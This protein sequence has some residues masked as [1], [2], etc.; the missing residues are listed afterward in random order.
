MEEIAYAKL[1]LALHVRAREPDGY[2]R[3]ETLFAF[4]AD[5]DRLRVEEGEGLSLSITGPFAAGL[6]AGEDN[7][8][9]R[10]A[11]ALRDRFGVNT[12]AH[13]TLEKNLPVASGIGGGSADAAAALRLLARWWDIAGDASPSAPA[14]AGAQPQQSNWAPAFAGAQ[15]SLYAEIEEIAQTLGADVPACL[16]SRT[17]RG[18]GRG[19]RLRP[20]DLGLAG[21][22]VL[23]VNPRVAVSTAA[24]FKGWDGVD[25]GPMPDDPREARNDLQPPAC[26]LAPEIETVLAALAAQPGATFTR[27]SG[28]GATCFALFKDEAVRDAASACIASLHPY[29]WRLAI[30]LL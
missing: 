1:N 6:S 5:G 19:D 14:K 2:H 28:S 7:L 29:W 11:H 15:R 27:M 23:L 17:A 13:L 12:G 3:I 9:L 24:V 25:K 26:A 10:A 18:D 16:A 22:P 4:C 21:T 20:V 8:V 30:S